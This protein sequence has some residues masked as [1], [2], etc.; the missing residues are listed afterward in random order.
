MV[1]IFMTELSSAIIV[2]DVP[3][4]FVILKNYWGAA[5]GAAELSTGLARQKVL[6][7]GIFPVAWLNYWPTDETNQSWDDTFGQ[8]GEI[9]VEAA[10]SM[11]SNFDMWHEEFVRTFS[12]NE[13]AN[14]GCVRAMLLH[15]GPNAGG[16]EALLK[17]WKDC[18]QKLQQRS[19]SANPGMDTITYGIGAC[20]SYTLM[21]LGRQDLAQEYLLH[22]G[23]DPEHADATMDI[24]KTFAGLIFR[25]RGATEGGFFSME[26]LS[27]NHKAVGIW[28]MDED[29]LGGIGAASEMLLQCP[30]PEALCEVG[31]CFPTHEHGHF[32]CFTSTAFQVKHKTQTR[33]GRRFSRGVE[34]HSVTGGLLQALAHE[35]IAESPNATAA[36]ARTPP[37]CL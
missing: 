37:R 22:L 23:T 6:C 28:I 13:F 11:A 12:W 36:Q 16:C 21:L 4:M 33:S 10:A 14:P 15:W 30:D 18:L 29:R 5:R 26:A 7:Q 24:W 20:Q 34:M 8:G 31:Q 27:W 17:S 3:A 1:F 32:V 2:G 35:R 25:G 19:T 9:L